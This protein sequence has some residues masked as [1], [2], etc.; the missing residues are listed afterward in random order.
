MVYSDMSRK[1][2][3]TPTL[4]SAQDV[5]TRYHDGTLCFVILGD[6]VTKVDARMGA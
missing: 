2:I 5:V 4:S 6:A 1:S 3:C